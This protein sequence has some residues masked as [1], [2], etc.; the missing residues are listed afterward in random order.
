MFSGAALL[1][2]WTSKDITKTFLQ[3]MKIYR[4]LELFLSRPSMYTDEGNN[5]VQDHNNISSRRIKLMTIC[6]AKVRLY[7]YLLTLRCLATPS[8]PRSSESMIPTS[9]LFPH[10]VPQP[11]T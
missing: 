3:A 1:Q 4:I 7:P 10:D 8:Y 11:S 2:I 9:T 5:I 6:Y